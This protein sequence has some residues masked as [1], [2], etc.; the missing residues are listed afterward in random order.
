MRSFWRNALHRSEMERNMS[1]E[2]RFHL[3]RRAEDL[4]ERRG[5]APEEAMRIA[6]LEFGSVEKYKEEARQSL[7]L[8][9]LDEVRGDLRYALRGF[10]KSK[11][12]TV[13]AIAT[14]AVGIGANTAIFSVTDSVMLR[15]L[16][17]QR[18]QELAAILLQKPGRPAEDGFTN[19]LW[20]AIRD[21]QDVFSGAFA[22][23]S[24][25]PF[26][27]AQGGAVRN[28]QG[29]M[30][31]G[32]YFNTLGIKPGAGRL[33]VAGDDHRGC[34]PLAV[35][36]HGFWQAQFGRTDSALGSTISLNQ[37][38]F[39]VIGVTP[40]H[41]H[42]VDVG[43]NFDVAI[44]LCA[45]AL[46]DKRNLDSRSRWWLSIIGRVKPG[47]TPDRIN[48][49]LAVLSPEIMT[50]ALPDW[51]PSGQQQ[52]LARR[53]VTAPAGTG[54]SD[55]RTAFREPLNIL[56][57]IVALVLSIAC[58]N[59]ASL[60]LARATTSGKEIAIRKALGASRSRLVRQLLTES[61][62]LSSVGAALGLV[63]AQ[64][65]SALLVRNL[66][67]GRNPLFLDLSLD[68]RVLGFTVIITVVTAM[69]IGL[70]PALR[71]TRIGLMEAMK[72]RSVA[73]SEQRSRFR[74]GKW[75]VAGQV[76]LSLVLLIGG[77]LLLRTFVKLFTLDLGFDR[78]NV[79][80]VS[81]KPPW[82]AAD[83]AKLPP[84]QRQAI[85]D[86]IARRLRAIPGVIS[87]ARSFTTPIGDDNWVHN[88]RTDVP[89]APTGDEATTYFNFVT[90]GY[91]A[92][93]RTPV[94]AGR[95]FDDHDTQ[96]SSRVAIV[97]ETLA[98]K[99]FPGVNALGRT[100]RRGQEAGLVEIVGI[101]KDSKY[102][103]VRQVAP[104]TAFLPA[105]QAPP[106]GAAEDFAVRT[107]V[108]P[109][110]VITEVQHAVT[111]V[112]SD[113]PLKF[114]TLAE[115]I[116]DNLVKE[117]LVATLSG[118]FGVLALLLAMIGLYGVLSYL[119]TERQIEFG[120][121][122]A[123]GAQPISILRLVMREVA[124]VL[125]GGLATGLAVAL[126][127]VTLLERM[128]FGLQ[129]RDTLTMATAVCLLSTMALLAAYLPA[130]RA[131]RMNPMAALR[132]E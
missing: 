21:R 116:D 10:G 107:A 75:I 114:H 40:R 55:L 128:L 74:L 47:T 70:L 66:S 76:A 79:L 11:G 37:Q 126:A 50:A 73:G 62:L 123:L 58:A 6:R 83:T 52:F 9:L 122:M 93:M 86:E 84:E 35:L 115:E 25:K 85:Y 28:V 67:T 97:N 117:R 18:P 132:S 78:N 119:V 95:D 69:L 61:A 108:P 103:A 30:V 98:R 7:G 13:A 102:E 12:F 51:N 72:A 92:T 22:W 64:W 96:S 45:S 77:G 88:I 4:V 60:M 20:E 63:F 56:M 82:F 38:L 111:D 17:V 19:A 15:L 43:K 34:A 87:V 1:D 112:T 42:G 29:L 124:L 36:S 100:F 109:A 104:P 89:G 16:P 46:F 81:A 125:A 130:R 129:P 121:R 91:F 59:I 31:S 71:S 53:L 80:V 32:D 68:G 8:E 94:V 106:A 5:L 101:V 118:F 120:I 90:P 33:L 27:F 110:T 26:A 39:Q 105:T 127:S 54:A 3:A 65:G 41:F 14:L 48:A 113:I 131:T 57:V 44:P 24:P 49:R 99:F 2:L 23:S